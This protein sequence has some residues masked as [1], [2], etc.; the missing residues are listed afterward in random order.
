MYPSSIPVDMWE[1][2]R[3]SVCMTF[4]SKLTDEH[5][6]ALIITR[7]PYSLNNWKSTSVHSLWKHE[8][9]EVSHLSP[10]VSWLLRRRLQSHSAER[11][12]KKR[13]G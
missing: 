4:G 7:K 13:R 12:Q 5:F 2:S 6:D 9:R 3:E 10:L 8:V 1:Q 11:L